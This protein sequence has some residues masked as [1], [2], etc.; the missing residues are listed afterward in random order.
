MRG[1]KLVSF[2]VLVAFCINSMFVMVCKLDTCL[3]SSGMTK[4]FLPIAFYG[5]LGGLD[6]A[7]F[8]GSSFARVTVGDKIKQIDIRNTR[9]L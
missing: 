6:L 4:G 1:S 9:Y 7:G 8:F 2:L 5:P 3:T